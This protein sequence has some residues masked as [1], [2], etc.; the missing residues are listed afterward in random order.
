MQIG[1]GPYGF[2]LR[3]DARRDL[4][5]LAHNLGIATEIV[6]ELRVASPEEPFHYRAK[7]CLGRRP[8][9]LSAFVSGQQGLEID[10]AEFRASINYKDLRDTIVAGHAF[11]DDCHAGAITGWIEG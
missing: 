5:Y 11:S 8:G 3:V 9:F 7:A 6:D 10:T 2:L 1:Q 4:S